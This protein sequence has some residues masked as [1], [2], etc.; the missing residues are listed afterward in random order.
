MKLK[1]PL[2]TIT[3]RSFIRARQAVKARTFGHF[4]LQ[5]DAGVASAFST[6]NDNLLL[7]KLSL[8]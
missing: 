5:R 2:V 8:K 6:P 4:E 1:E 3:T 7:E